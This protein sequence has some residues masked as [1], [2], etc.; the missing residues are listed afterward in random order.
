M[1][2]RTPARDIRNGQSYFELTWN[3]FRFCM[4]GIFGVFTVVY[5]SCTLLVFLCSADFNSLP[6]HQFFASL[7]SVLMCGLV[8]IGYA[9]MFVAVPVSAFC[10]SLAF[11]A[12]GLIKVSEMF[13]V[14]PKEG[15]FGW[16]HQGPDAPLPDPR[17]ST[18]E[19]H[20]DLKVALCPVCSSA[21]EG[22][23][24]KCVSCEIP[25]HLECWDYVGLCSTFGCGCERHGLVAHCAAVPAPGDPVDESPAAPKEAPPHV[26]A[27]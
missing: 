4:K 12:T 11:V 9:M 14:N 24:V 20:V 23:Y 26:R 27:S 22:Q 17:I 15:P 8:M 19:V 21:L 1:S 13:L 16:A 10:A 25:H 5:L 18:S 6:P 3:I 2:R 7:A